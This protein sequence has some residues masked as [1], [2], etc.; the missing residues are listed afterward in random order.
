MSEGGGSV[1]IE[2]HAAH[3]QWQREAMGRGESSED[4]VRIKT[5]WDVLLFSLQPSHCQDS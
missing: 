1:C 5:Q 3:T 4:F 2:L